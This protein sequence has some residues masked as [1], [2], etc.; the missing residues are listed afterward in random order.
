MPQAP[1]LGL[2]VLQAACTGHQGTSHV[3]PGDASQS[4]E[5][6]PRRA[7]VQRCGQQWCADFH[8]LGVGFEL[9]LNEH[10]FLNRDFK[11]TVHGAPALAGVAQ[12]FDRT[13]LSGTLGTYLVEPASVIAGDV[14]SWGAWVARASFLLECVQ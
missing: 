5:V 6:L 10:R 13:W 4:S 7:R 12:G 1:W 9:R 2:L 3:T 8:A 11:F 14:A